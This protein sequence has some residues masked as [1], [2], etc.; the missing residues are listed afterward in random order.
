[1]N[2]YSSNPPGDSTLS[3]SVSFK[4]PTRV[5]WFFVLCGHRAPVAAALCVLH[6]NPS[7]PWIPGSLTDPGH[8]LGTLSI[9][10]LSPALQVLRRGEM[11]ERGGRKGRADVVILMSWCC[12]SRD[13]GEAVRKINLS[14]ILD[15]EWSGLFFNGCVCSCVWLSLFFSFFTLW[16][17]SIFSI[18]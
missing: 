11:R 14:E 2:T 1:M 7:S 13:S 9:S 16:S 4:R 5:Q 6:W 8:Q 17:R 12:C 10:P 18:L 3:V 15:Q